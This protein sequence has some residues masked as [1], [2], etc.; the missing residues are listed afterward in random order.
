MNITEI[1]KLSKNNPMLAAAIEGLVK[2][3]SVNP[4]IVNRGK[5][6]P[7]K[8]LKPPTNMKLSDSRAS[9]CR[10]YFKEGYTITQLCEEYGVSRTSIIYTLKDR[11]VYY[12]YIQL[13]RHYTRQFKFYWQ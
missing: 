8:Y 12:G 2:Q 6:K 5:E 4:N 13:P 3:Y 7:Y 1:K 9:I 11:G 10:K